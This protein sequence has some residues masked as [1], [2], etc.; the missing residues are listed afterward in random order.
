MTEREW[1]RNV[2]RAR[3]ERRAALRMAYAMAIE[4]DVARRRARIA[5]IVWIAT[6]AAATAYFLLTSW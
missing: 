5:L 4:A 2:V 1:L 3:R 6:A